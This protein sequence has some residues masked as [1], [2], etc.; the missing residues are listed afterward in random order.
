MNFSVI[1]NIINM[2]AICPNCNQRVNVCL[3][4]EE[5]KRFSNKIRT[6]CSSC[7]LKYSFCSSPKII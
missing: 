2:F 1:C 4:Q 5:R 6:L 7:G 3:L